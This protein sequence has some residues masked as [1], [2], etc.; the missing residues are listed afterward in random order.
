M[1]GVVGLPAKVT[2]MESAPEM[3]SLALR[4]CSARLLL[5]TDLYDDLTDDA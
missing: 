4:T 1:Q 2:T 3:A 5:R